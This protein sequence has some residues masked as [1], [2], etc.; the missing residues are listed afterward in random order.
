LKVK[1]KIIGRKH[2]GQDN[3]AGSGNVYLPTRPLSEKKAAFLEVARL[4]HPPRLHKQGKLESEIRVKKRM[5]KR[6]GSK[7]TRSSSGW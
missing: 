7:K 4:G 6:E 2:G 3:R 1:W 5:E